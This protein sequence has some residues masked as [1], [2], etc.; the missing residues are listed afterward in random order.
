MAATG[1]CLLHA[2][3]FHG[4]GQH[5]SETIGVD[6]IADAGHVCPHVACGYSPQSFI[7]LTIILQQHKD[8]SAQR[9]ID[10]LSYYQSLYEQKCRTS[11][12]DCASQNLTAGFWPAQTV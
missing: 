12:F 9:C 2:L 5:L 4:F 11:M 1:N 8:A 10:G 3:Q 7:Y 6:A